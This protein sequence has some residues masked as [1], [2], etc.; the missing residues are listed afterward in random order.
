MIRSKKLKNIFS[1]TT[2]KGK[3]IATTMLIS[4]L[5]VTVS[6]VLLTS[7]G[8]TERENALKQEMSTLVNMLGRR[9]AVALSFMNKDFS[10]ESLRYLSEISNI[11][12]ACLYDKGGNIFANYVK[13]SNSGTCADIEKIS[14][15]IFTEETKFYEEHL[16]VKKNIFS[17]GELVGIISLRSNLVQINSYIKDQILIAVAIILGLFLLSYFVALKLQSLI[18]RPILDV[19]EMTKNISQTQDYSARA[20]EVPYKE[21]KILV[22]TFNTVL[23][24]RE[25]LYILSREEHRLATK[26]Y[27][28]AKQ[29]LETVSKKFKQTDDAAYVVSA[30]MEDKLLGDDLVDYM[31]YVNDLGKTVTGYKSHLEVFREL[32]LTYERTLNEEKNDLNLQDVVNHFIKLWK[33]DENE[34]ELKLTVIS[35]TK[36]SSL[37]SEPLYESMKILFELLKSMSIYTDKNCKLD[38]DIDGSNNDSQSI[39]FSVVSESFIHEDGLMTEENIIQEIE[40]YVDCVRYLSLANNIYVQFIPSYPSFKIILLNG[41]ASEKVKNVVPFTIGKEIEDKEAN[42][43]YGNS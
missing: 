2:L 28:N 21:L 22:D 25:R 4:F 42:T 16:L 13:P 12:Q 9:N 10:T 41:Q 35:P 26:A 5:L 39:S 11:E 18:S 3:I 29:N 19:V 30:I 14:G 36:N 38:I 20:P 24:E 32:S 43:N 27:F 23:S 40:F 17:G 6:T 15:G 7:Y 33:K 31:P 37:Y 1:F 34:H 8:I